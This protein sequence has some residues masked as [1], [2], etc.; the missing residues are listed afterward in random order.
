MISGRRRLA[1]PGALRF[2]SPLLALLLLMAS[3]AAVAAL[4]W[5]AG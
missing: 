3:A 2:A 5:F 1:D 4:I